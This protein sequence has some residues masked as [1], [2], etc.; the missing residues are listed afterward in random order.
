M[1][2]SPTNASRCATT[3]FAATTILGAEFLSWEANIVTNYSF[4]V[5]KGWTYSQPALDV[6]NATFCNVTVTY[7]HTGQNDT[8][9]VEAWLPTEENY[10]GRLQSV[11]GGGWTPGRFILSYSA[12][13]NAVAGGY[14]TVTTDAGIP[15]TQSPIDWLLTSPGNLDTTSLQNFGQVALKDEAIIA[16]QLIAAFYGK[17]PEYSYW[18]GCSQGGRQGL[19]VAQQY[20]DIYDGIMSAAPAINWAEFYI[21]SI[22]PSFYME[23]TQQFPRDCELNEITSLA[24]HACDELDGVKDGLISDP[25]ACREKFNVF[26]HVGESF[27]CSS[28]NSTLTISQAAASVANASW[29]GPR[30]S[31]GRF[32][33]DGYEIGSDLPTIA[34][35]SCSGEVCTS[36]GL[37]NILFAWQAFVAKDANATLPNITDRT[38]DTIYRA[39]KLVFASNLETDEVDLRDFRDAGGKLMTY[40]GLADQSISPGGTLRYYNKVADFV[41]NVT[42]FYKYY[43]VPGLGHCWGGNGGQPE[44]IFSQLRAWVENGTEPQSSPVVVTRSDNTTQQQ[45]LCPY[46]QKAIFDASCNIANST[47]CWSCSEGTP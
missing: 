41:G 35:T 42:S 19:K 23:K 25:E 36:A 44:A 30:F 28:S 6:Q 2:F 17:E 26:E 7:T 34:P 5:P 29:T 11:G 15:T 46:P 4:N 39:V 13:I 38:F 24:I 32:M 21:N 43:R 8:L 1:V 40:H 37:P 31:N 22:W 14:A 20:E 12:M 16:K 45:V 3:T 33:Y 9:N 10:N 47:T 27:R 18:N